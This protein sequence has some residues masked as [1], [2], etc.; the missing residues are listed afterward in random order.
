ML[1]TGDELRTAIQTA[2]TE[3][4]VLIEDL[5]YAKNVLMVAGAPGAGKSIVM[6][7][8]AL[9]ASTGSRLFGALPIPRPLRVYYLQLEGSDNESFARMRRMQD[10][11]PLNA[12]NLAWDFRIGLNLLDSHQADQLLLDVAAWGVVPD[13]FILDPLYQ[14]V[15]GEIS[16]ELPSMALIRFIDLL[17]TRFG[18][19]VILNH[20]THREKHDLQGRPVE[21]NDPFYGSQWLKAYVDTS[22]LLKPITGKYK[23]RVDLL[24]KK[25]RHSACLKQLMLHFDPESDTVSLDIPSGHRSSGYERV[26]AFL[27]RC[28]QENRTTHFHEVME[29]CNLSA[30]HLHRIQAILLAKKVVR[31]DKRDSANNLRRI[32]ETL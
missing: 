27:L 1:R 14:A 7:Q 5:L 3:Q 22:Y 15:F 19:A 9:A 25:D 10:Q 32:W 31:C 16:K 4:P 26:L 24:N 17:R 6:T 29:E 18:C 13:I 21:E 23:N 30:S 12:N 20:H 11:V 8:L 2:S 28:R